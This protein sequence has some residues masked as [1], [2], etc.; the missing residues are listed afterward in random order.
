MGWGL[1][2]AV[3]HDNSGQLISGSFLEYVLPKAGAVPSVETVLVENPSQNGPFGTRGVG[4]PPVTAVAAAVANA[5]LDA[6]GK[7]MFELP[8]T[9]ENLWKALS[10]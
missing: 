3:R 2:E 8:I 9:P 5:V 1:H 4:E 7:R 10:S 6:T